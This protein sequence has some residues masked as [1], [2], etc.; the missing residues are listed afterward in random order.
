MKTAIITDSAANL[1]E[2]FLQENPFVFVVPLVIVMDGVS[3]RDQVEVKAEEVY[4]SLEEKTIT[5]SLPDT[6][7]LLNTIEMIK[8]E[9]YDQA[10]LITISSALSGTYNAF[11]LALEDVL[12]PVTMYDSKTLAGGEGLLVEEASELVK[13]EVEIPEII[14]ALDKQRYENSLA[15]YTVHTLKYLRKGGRIGKVEGTIGDILHI[16]P[17]IT[18]NEEGAYITLGKSFGLLRTL[19]KMKDLFVKK[20]QNALIDLTIHYGDDLEKAKSLAGQLMES[21]RIRKLTISPITPVLGIHTGPMMFAYI[22]RL[23]QE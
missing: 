21:L 15:M 1:T 13:K 5:T 18:V 6:N 16:K 22:G 11:R 14:Q 7:D 23:V 17:I 19:Q 4:A 10:L 9:G 2:E 8:K 3:F 20:F 12:F